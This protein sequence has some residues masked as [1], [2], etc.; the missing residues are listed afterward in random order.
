V[1]QTSQNVDMAKLRRVLDGCVQNLRLVHRPKDGLFP[2]SSRLG[3]TPFVDDYRTPESFRYTINTLLGLLEAG[4]AGIAGLDVSDVEAMTRTFLAAHGHEIK[5]GAD[6]GLLLL[7]LSELGGFD[8]EAADTVTTLG[9]VVGASGLNMQDLGWIVWGA[10]G[11]TRVGVAGAAE[12]G[13]RATALIHDEYVHPDSGMPRH[14]TDRYRRNVVS[15]GSF[16]YFLRAM[17]EASVTFEDSRSAELFRIGVDRALAFQGPLGEWP[18]MLDVRTGT[19]FDVY[20]VFSVHQ[21]SMAMLFLLPA[22]DAGVS[23]AAPAIERS[24]RWCFGENECGIEF[25]RYDPFFAF[26]SIERVDRWPRLRRY[27]RSLGYSV[28]KRPGVFGSAGSPRLN[29]ECR[30]YHLG[31][32]LYAWAGRL[33]ATPVTQEA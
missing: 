30:S 22:L 14:T 16:V 8:Q 13:R 32:I 24:L 25:Y 17:S 9:P 21:D 11:A 10:A 18:W 26:R 4:R 2:Y 31:W 27:L 15:F 28:T 12:L 23:R 33:G 5:S 20:P 3:G 19:P 1:T 29:D 7:L 6:R